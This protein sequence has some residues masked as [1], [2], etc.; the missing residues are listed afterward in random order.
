MADFLNFRFGLRRRTQSLSRN[1]RQIHSSP[2]PMC[3]NSLLQIRSRISLAV[4]QTFPHWL[5]WPCSRAMCKKLEFVVFLLKIQ[6]VNCSI[7]VPFHCSSPPRNHQRLHFPGRH[8][9]CQDSQGL[10]ALG[11]KGTHWVFGFEV[12][13]SKNDLNIDSVTFI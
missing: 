3:R 1:P 8:C 13:F 9:F 11:T 2:V 12:F 10:G 4:D 6:H 7:P 5:N